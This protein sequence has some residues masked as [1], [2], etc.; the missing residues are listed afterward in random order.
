LI[1]FL[2]VEWN[3]DDADTFGS[4][5]LK[6]FFIWRLFYWHA[7]EADACGN[8]DFHGFLCRYLMEHG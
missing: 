2:G 3:T 5:D 6:G 1:F 8:A 4:T 7:D